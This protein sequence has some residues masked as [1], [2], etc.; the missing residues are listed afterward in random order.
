MYILC[1]F[2]ESLSLSFKLPIPHGLVELRA[3]MKY[4]DISSL[5]RQ[6]YSSMHPAYS[7]L[8]WST[9]ADKASPRQ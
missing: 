4:N 5:C 1:V 3:K 2:S 9:V 6:I 7:V 8:G